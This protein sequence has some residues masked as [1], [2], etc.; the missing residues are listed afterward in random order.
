[1]EDADAV[2][3][4]MVVEVENGRRIAQPPSSSQTFQ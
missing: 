4:V 1:M 3:V 2:V